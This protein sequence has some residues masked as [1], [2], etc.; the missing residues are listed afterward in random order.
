[1]SQEG[2]K[3]LLN[4]SSQIQRGTALKGLRMFITLKK[5]HIYIDARKEKK[6]RDHIIQNFIKEETED[7]EGKRFAQNQRTGDFPP[8]SPLYMGKVRT[9]V[10]KIQKKCIY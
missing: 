2:N 7:R 9:H 3:V 6:L 8:Y 4:I 1:M 10:F 5:M